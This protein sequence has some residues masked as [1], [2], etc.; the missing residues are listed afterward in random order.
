MLGREVAV[1][2]TW[3]PARE[4]PSALLK[5]TE[6]II[7][8]ALA[9]WI[10]GGEKL[11]PSREGTQM[12]KERIPT[13]GVDPTLMEGEQPLGG[14]LNFR[15]GIGASQHDRAERFAFRPR[16]EKEAMRWLP[17]QRL[18]HGEA[19]SAQSVPSEFPQGLVDRRALVLPVELAQHSSA[20]GGETVV[21]SDVQLQLNAA[22]LPGG[23]TAEGGTAVAQVSVGAEP[24]RQHARQ[25]RRQLRGSTEQGEARQSRVE[26]KRG[27][28]QRYSLHAC[29]R[30]CSIHR[31]H[32]RSSLH[33]P[34]GVLPIDVT[35]AFASPFPGRPALPPR[36]WSN[37][38]D[39]VAVSVTSLTSA[40]LREMRSR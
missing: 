37:P 16:Q 26:G 14:T 19:P 3:G 24:R 36:S 40:G 25:G 6:Q 22:P 31:D 20:P 11:L 7:Q 9:F 30:R 33:G 39:T 13:T 21:A 8:E 4:F 2:R 17:G 5:A 27:R 28:V 15:R 32:D 12:A 23:Q 34:G 29:H 10:D 35:A 1:G 18:R 38:S